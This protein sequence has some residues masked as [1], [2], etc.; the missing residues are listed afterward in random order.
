MFS[1]PASPYN[2]DKG[3]IFL[4]LE[5]CEHDLAGILSNRSVKFTLGEIKKLLQQLFN[6][7]Y[8]MHYSKVLHRDMKASNILITKD[9]VLKIADF[10]LARGFTAAKNQRF[11]NRVVT[12]WYRPPEILLGDR[13]YGPAIDLWGAGC[14]MAEMW[15][16]SPILQGNSEQQQ[17]ELI[18]RLCG[19]ITPEEWPGV[20]KLEYFTKMKLLPKEIR[21]VKE[22]L[23]HPVKDPLGIDL[24]DKLLT[25]DPKMRIDSDTALKH[26]FFYH[27]P[28][29]ENPQKTLKLLTTSN[30]EL[31]APRP[32]AG[33]APPPVYLPQTGSTNYPTT[34]VSST[35]HDRVY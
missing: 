15:T 9:G 31:L 5:F 20:E 23:K 22:R 3:S 26:D 2:R 18:S 1:S 7:L 14:I 10:G 35:V 16:R 29:P 11:T 13:H 32:R 12:L 21:K 8:Y 4:V 33:P 34:Q 27:A 30:F 19:S 17:L 28:P 25:L 24:L 6:G